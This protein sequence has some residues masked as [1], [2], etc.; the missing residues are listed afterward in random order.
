MAKKPEFKM[1]KTFG[2]CADLLYETQQKRYALQRE[3]EALDK[4]E[5]LIEQHVIN[6]M[7]KTD[8]G[9]QG[10]MARI[11]LVHKQVPRV[12][13]DDVEAGTKDGWPA[14]RKF[15]AK[16]DRWDFLYKRL[17]DKAIR[18]M[19]DDKKTVPGVVPFQVVTVSVKK[20]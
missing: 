4:L 2:G 16:Y 15:I 10:K 19:W 1:P 7:P 13:V 11:E 20:A 9:A 3:A 14:L 6:N 12:T 5:T 8:G 18:E 17:N